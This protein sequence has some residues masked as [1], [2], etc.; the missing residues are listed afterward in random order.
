MSGWDQGWALGANLAQDRV[1]RKRQLADEERQIK[2]TDLINT[3]NNILTKLPT[4]LGPNGEKTPEYDQ[5]YQSLTQA[6]QDL[7]QLY[8]PDRAPGALQQDWHWLLGKLHGIA[9]PK[10]NTPAAATPRI[11]TSDQPGVASSTA[12]GMAGEPTVLPS[13]G[14]T[15][16]IALGGAPPP[17]TSPELPAYKQ[18]ALSP[19][20]PAAP[21]APP[22]SWGQAQVLKQRAASLHRAQEQAGLLAAGAGLSPGQEAMRQFQAQDAVRQAQ[23]DSSLKLAEKL[24]I[25]GPAMEEFKQQ[26][27]GLKNVV[28]RAVTGP[29]GQPYKGADGRY[30]KPVLQPDGVTIGS[31]PMPPDWKPNTKAVSGSIINS[32]Q[33][34]WIKIWVDPYNPSKIVGFQ[35]ITPGRQYAGATS[36]STSTDPFGLTTT[37]SRSTMPTTSAPVDVDFAGMQELPSDYD[38]SSL[39]A[40]PAAEGQAAPSAPQ[41][42][43]SSRSGSAAGVPKPASPRESV[44]GSP[45]KTSTPARLKTQVPA[46]PQTLTSGTGNLQLDATGHIPATAP[47]NSNLIGAANQ[48]LDGMDIG[49]LTIPQ[50]A[51]EAA[52]NLARAYGW[53]G[54]GMFNPQQKLQI[55][56]A[57]TFLNDAIDSPALS[58][59]NNWASRQ[60][61]IAAINNSE[62]HPGW[63]DS[64][65]ARNLDLNP[66]E[67]EFLRMFRQLTGTI[68]GLASLTR[69]GRP[70][71]AGIR[72]LMS[73]LPNP[74]ESH[75][76]ADAKARLKRLT[77]EI[78]IATQKGNADDL[79]GSTSSSVAAQHKVGDPVLLNGNIVVIKK[80][81][82]DGTF[83]Y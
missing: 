52:S 13:T 2:A 41:N 33:Y 73:E 59:L 74:N 80:I 12:P 43:V 49:K 20:A 82:P 3:R 38:G 62:N 32:K 19:A 48:L 68:S 50:K 6:Q 31:I 36:T 1:A 65:I 66:Q 77:R 21:K 46:P 58:V 14:T 75:S 37:S 69:P 7:G 9:A 79:L 40:S 54:Q 64:L 24:G 44:S 51:K 10:E 27:V 57:S 47:Y 26:L 15:P 25:T 45:S 67:A 17:I 53:G 11:A 72:R 56:E 55:K 29:A 78:E 4:L 35:K 8:H 42:V 63:T 5:A 22:A 71:E 30:Y 70:T 81:N 76:A 18:T 16:E 23:V 28:P 61:I 83:D 39:P 34:G 60:K